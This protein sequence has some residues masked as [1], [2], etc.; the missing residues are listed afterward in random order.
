[1]SRSGSAWSGAARIVAAAALLVLP[2]GAAEGARP[3]SILTVI[4]ADG[5][6][7]QAVPVV[8]GEG[9]GS[10]PLVPLVPL[11]RALGVPFSWD[12]FTFR[13]WI[14]PD[15]VRIGFSLASRVVVRGSEAAQLEGEV[16]YGAAGVLLPIDLLGV[17]AERWNGGR[18]AEWDPGRGRLDWGG[19]GPP[20]RGLRYR[21]IGHRT[22][23]E[24]SSPRPILGD[25]Y[26][27]PAGGLE[28]RLAGISCDPD[29]MRAEP[30]RGSLSLRTAGR[31]RSG[32]R[33]FFDVD[34]AVVGVSQSYDETD[35]TWRLHATTSREELQR[36]GFAALQRLA[37]PSA[38]SRGP[39]LLAVWVDP[40]ADPAEV[41]TSL[42]DLA[43]RAAEILSG[44][45]GIETVILE[46][47]DPVGV[48]SRANGYEARALVGLRVDRYLA[49][50]DRI[51]IIAGAARTP[52]GRLS[53]GE[54]DSLAVDRP[55]LWSET[56]GLTAGRSDRLARNL[57][58]HLVPVV[59]AD[60]LIV[61]RR[62]L[63]WL[64]GLT[65]PAVAVYPA[66][67]NDSASMS[68]LA[69]AQQR[70]D[71]ARGIAIGISEAL[72]GGELEGA[73]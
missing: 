62:P 47:S 16:G 13:G 70:A 21:Q 55:P 9:E 45:L 19:E 61:A 66:A 8:S 72:R 4:P 1:M 11:A 60:R 18:S 41:G 38:N 51:Q 15:S 69:S 23:V 33:L 43:E 46:G 20:A 48:A 30:P 25:L 10:V 37:A 50:I 40:L 44:R 49:P 56:P 65:M 68:R 34:R 26:W 12:P 59:G 24:I 63:E 52:W 29:S 42:R 35:R 58:E 67:G 5:R 39:I 54:G 31:E 14:E 6:P 27:S 64:E 73:P 36:G 2:G 22:T 17:L 3:D 28:A 7:P 53:R 71:L 57:A 32:C